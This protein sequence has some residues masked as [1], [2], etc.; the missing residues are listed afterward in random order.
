M[1]LSVKGISKLPED[2]TYKK[3][4]TRLRVGGGS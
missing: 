4:G 1:L 2:G 3:K